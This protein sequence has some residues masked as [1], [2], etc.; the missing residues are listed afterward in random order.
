MGDISKFG[1]PLDGEKLGILQPKLTTRYRV[2]FDNF[3]DGDAQLREMTQNVQ[4]VDRPTLSHDI[5]EV[6]SYVSRAYIAGKHEWDTINVVLRDDI[7]NAV[8]SAVGAQLQKQTN[9]FE[10]TSAISG[11]NYKFNMEI[12]S[13]GGGNDEQLEAWELIGCFLS[14]VEYPE[15]DYTST[16]GF[17]TVSM[18]VRYD[19]AVQ[20][21]GPFDNDGNTVGGNPFPNT[22]SP[23]GGI[24][25]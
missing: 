15:G 24:S 25:V 18:T 3:G 10:Q 5:V 19:N 14:N 1:I 2:I 6:H 4:S 13:L 23:I 11:S 7:T 17:H 12:H 22:S 21:A 20:I 8:V 16:D 9:H